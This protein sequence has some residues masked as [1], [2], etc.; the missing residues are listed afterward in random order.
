M[1]AGCPTSRFWTWDPT[2]S[3]QPSTPNPLETRAGADDHTDR[4]NNLFHR[5]R[6][7]RDDTKI[8]QGKPERSPGGSPGRPA[9]KNPAAP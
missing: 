8:A 6:P 7:G 1:S 4:G 5:S 9:T 3:T 2:T